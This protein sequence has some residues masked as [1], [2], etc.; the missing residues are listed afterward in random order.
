M[1]KPNKAKETR[2]QGTKTQDTIVQDRRQAKRVDA[3][4]QIELSVDGSGRAEQASAINI[5]A[6]GAYFSSPRY[7]EP[8]TKLEMRLL[9]PGEDDDAAIESFDVEGIVVRVE[10]EEPGPQGQTYEIACYFTET[11]PEFRER[12]GRYVQARF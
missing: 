11:T 8:L 3:R 7:L 10:P 6:S 4:L 1:T 12:L 9:L 2:A 5:S